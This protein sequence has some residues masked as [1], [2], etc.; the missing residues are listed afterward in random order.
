MRNF[1]VTSPGTVPQGKKASW[2]AIFCFWRS[3]RVFEYTMLSALE[4]SGSRRS[5]SQ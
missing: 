1:V 5:G 3:G 2:R 4:P